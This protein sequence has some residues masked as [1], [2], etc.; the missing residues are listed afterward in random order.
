MGFIQIVPTLSNH[1][2]KYDNN[3]T[4]GWEEADRYFNKKKSFGCVDFK[5]VYHYE[6]S[7]LFCL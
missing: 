1:K 2:K 6:I 5:N 4:K 7:N 3:V